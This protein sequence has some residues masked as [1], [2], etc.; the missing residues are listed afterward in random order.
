MMMN[1]H[2]A[3]F[4]RGDRTVSDATTAEED[5]AQPQTIRSA[6]LGRTGCDGGCQQ[7]EECGLQRL[8]RFGDRVWLLLKVTQMAHQFEDLR[9]VVAAQAQQLHYLQHGKSTTPSGSF[10]DDEVS[11]DEDSD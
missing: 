10:D 1:S 2:S 4:V 7:A 6:L 9:A 3:R 11:S 5:A 8:H